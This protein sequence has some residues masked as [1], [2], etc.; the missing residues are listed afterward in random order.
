MLEYLETFKYRDSLKCFS[1]LVIFMEAKFRKEY[2]AKLVNLLKEDKSILEEKEVARKLN[3]SPI[4]ASSLMSHIEEYGDI[5][6]FAGDEV[7]E[8]AKDNGIF[9]TRPKEFYC[10]LKGNKESAIREKVIEIIQGKINEDNERINLEIDRLSGEKPYPI[11]EKVEK[12]LDDVACL[13]QP[14]KMA[15][16][17][18]V[19]N[20][21]LDDLDRKFCV[22]RG[23]VK[24]SI[25][26]VEIDKDNLENFKT[27]YKA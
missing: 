27:K 25:N 24:R 8:T 21:I 2:E 20:F 3:I 23:L 5:E 12:L 26:Q 16:Y 11:L 22:R 19:Y 4:R 17:N 1:F 9:I 6:T 10:T 15:C 18:N 14:D 13:K 7:Y